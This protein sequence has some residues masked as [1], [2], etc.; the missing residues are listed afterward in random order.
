MAA[1][2]LLYVFA[3]VAYLKVLTIP[4]IA[5]TERVGADLAIRT[6]GPGGGTFLSLTVMLSIVGAVNG[7][8]LTA[9]RIPFAQARDGLFFARFGRV[10]PRF[11]TPGFAILC[12]GLWSMILVLTGSYE[13]LYTYSIV[14]AWIFYT[15]SVAAVFVLRRKL[16]DLPRPYRM[17]GYPWTLGLFVAVSGWFMVNAF[18]TQPA[19]S[20]MAFS[21]VGTGALGYGLWRRLTAAV[22]S[23]AGM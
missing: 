19:P 2:M 18:V 4:E 16:P 11:Q 14:A 7:C 13:T 23:R 17:W 10:H 20:W 5:A 22:G 3:N 12:G 1:V 6:M 15:L 8:V 21:I 9:A